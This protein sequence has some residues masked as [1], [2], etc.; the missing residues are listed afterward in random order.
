MPGY[1]INVGNCEIISFTDI[2]MQFPWSMFFPSLREDDYEPYRDLYPACYGDR[3]YKTD[4]GAYAI[5]SSGKTVVVD[6]GLGYGPHPW[7]GG[8]TGRLAD[9]M[10]EKGVAP[11]SADI[12]LHTHLHGDHVGWNITDGKPTFPN[13]T[14]YAPEEDMKFF[15]ASL[16]ANPQMKDQVLPLR[17]MGKL[18][19]FSGE[20][21]LT[22]DLTTVPT[23]GHTPGHASLL[24]ASGGEKAMIMGDVAHH[25]MQIDRPEWSPGFDVDGAA[26]A[27]TRAAVTDRLEKENIIAAFCHFPGDGFG[28]VVREANRRVFQAL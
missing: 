4:A 7:L 2:T 16:A 19:T 17:E 11:E 15:E 23:P 10:R 3:G 18:K 27:V 6:T 26:A 13:A 9:D 12:V 21:S 5:R 14:Y 24:V 1:K 20:T 22:D 28:R 8:T 25:P